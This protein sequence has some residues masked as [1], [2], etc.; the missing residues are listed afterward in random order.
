MNLELIQRDQLHIIKGWFKLSALYVK[1]NDLP[2]VEKIKKIIIKSPLF[3]CILFLFVYEFLD[4][5]VTEEVD[6]ENKEDFFYKK[7]M[8][9]RSLFF[10]TFRIIV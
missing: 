5:V 9:A 2:S 4:D 6:F 3:I 8:Q 10:N 7:T 1:V